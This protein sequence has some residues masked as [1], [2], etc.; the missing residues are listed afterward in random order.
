MHHGLQDSES[1]I[2]WREKG[3]SVRVVCTVDRYRCIEDLS[4][5]TSNYDVRKN[6]GYENEDRAQAGNVQSSGACDDGVLAHE[7]EHNPYRTCYYRMLGLGA[8]TE[9]TLSVQACPKSSLF[10]TRFELNQEHGCS[11]AAFWRISVERGLRS[12]CRC[13]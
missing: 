10:T 9:P 6:Q 4:L 3:E 11:V 8:Y 2:Q 7:Q 5:S 12:L 1:R 13:I